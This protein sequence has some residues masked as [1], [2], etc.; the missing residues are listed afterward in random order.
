MYWLA[1]SNIAKGMII[2][3]A[4]LIPGFSGG[5]TAIILDIYDKLVSAV[6]S[7]FKN[8]KRNMMILSTV[9]IG[10]VLGIVL[11]SRV[12]LFITGFFRVPML[13]LF[14]GAVLGSIPML[15]KKAELTKFSF[16]AI[17]FPVLGAA[18]VM[19]LGLLPKDMFE[20]GLCLGPTEYIIL[21]LSGIAL[22]IALILP[23]IS[24][25][26]MLL[27]LGLYEST[28]LSIEQRQ[29]SFLFVL[30]AGVLIGILLFTKLLE[31]AMNK[32]SQITYLMIIG[33]VLVSLREVFP[34]IPMGV[35][36]ISSILSFISGFGL[37]FVLSQ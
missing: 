17:I 27:V 36:L 5:T 26:Y 31:I 15:Y 12:M 13:F 18:F 37:I 29:V 4:M 19:I 14:T 33:F 28:L 30:A 34:G 24:F 22:S 7:F 10:G 3:A 32:Y 35:E 20:F 8:P 16:K 21:F 11:F 9:G 1:L 25:S 2:G 6:A 23:G